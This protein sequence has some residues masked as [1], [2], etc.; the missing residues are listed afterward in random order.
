MGWFVAAGI[1]R[2]IRSSMLDVLNSEYIR[3]ARIKG[4]TEIRVVWKHALRNAL[5]APLTFAGV[6]FALMIS[7]AIV[8]ETVFAW[9]GIGRLAYEAVLFRDFPVIQ[10]VV[11]TFA[12]LVIG[13]NI[14]TDLLYAYVDPRVRSS[15]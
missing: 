6:Y 10:G 1:M 5:L 14:I 2:L 13:V 8:T 15:A 12:V 7:S 4:V 9:P 3:M 11:L